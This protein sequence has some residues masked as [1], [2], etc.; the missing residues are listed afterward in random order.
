[1][2]GGVIEVS[3]LGPDRANYEAFESALDLQP[4]VHRYIHGWSDHDDSNWLKI[5]PT[6][7]VFLSYIAGAPLKVHF[8][9][10]HHITCSRL[11]IGGQLRREQPVLQ[12]LGRFRLLGVELKPTGFYR[13]LQHDAYPFTDDITEFSRVFPEHAHWVEQRLQPDAPIS[14]LIHGMEAFLR[15]RAENALAATKVEAVVK[16]IVRQNGLASADHLARQVNLSVRQ[17][18]RQFAAV[19]GV[20]PKHYAKIVQVN[21]VVAALMADDGK[22][23]QALAL[24]HGYYD[25][26][27]FVR[28]FQRFVSLNPSN[29][30]RSSSG[31]LRTFLGNSA[32]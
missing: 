6:G 12:S 4:F 1:M 30:L 7:G 16:E 22:R 25:H 20:P 26:A 3:G 2:R 8:S 23:L 11:F 14:S 32:R 13:L 19:V 17:L 31:F 5:P 21:T 15:Q 9:R 24:D 10:R 18:R 27:H 28:D 29:F